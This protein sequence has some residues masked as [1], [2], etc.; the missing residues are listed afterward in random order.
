MG[1]AIKQV[2]K[3]AAMNN[4]RISTNKLASLLNVDYPVL[5]RWVN[6]NKIPKNIDKLFSR[7]KTINTSRVTIIEKTIKDASIRLKLLETML[8]YA[9]LELEK[10]KQ[11]SL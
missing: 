11:D 8:T 4:P 5:Y 10:I 6:T 1:D 9:K 3:H 2:I 7:K